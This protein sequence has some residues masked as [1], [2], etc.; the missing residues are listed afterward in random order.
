MSF[1]N[2]DVVRFERCQPVR[3]ASKFFTHSHTDNKMSLRVII[4]GDLWSGRLFDGR[5]VDL[6]K[7]TL[8]P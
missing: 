7:D 8:D 6:I 1:D 4:N 5:I 2:D 3:V